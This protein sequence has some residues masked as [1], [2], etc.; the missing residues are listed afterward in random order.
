MTDRDSLEE[1]LPPG[2][3]HQGIAIQV[4]PLAPP[5]LEGLLRAAQENALIVVLDQVTDPQ[6]VGAVMRSAAAFGACG[7]V[8][9]DR[10]AP[11]TTGALA[12]AASGALERLPLIRVVNLARAL[13]Q[14]Q[15]EGYWCVGLDG[16]GERPLSDAKLDG[17][18][19]L[20][21]GAEDAGLRRLTI[22]HCDIVARLPT[23][24]EFGVLN[25]SAAAAAALYEC[26][27]QRK[28]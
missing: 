24:A 3:I 25:V 12:K 5:K 1:L 4:Q 2:A 23:E 10:H 18:I 20:I 21:M 11:P 6:N 16:T 13:E 9:Q 22:E 26:A 19:A 28:P 15:A 17:R 8:M 14:I 27:R 7:I